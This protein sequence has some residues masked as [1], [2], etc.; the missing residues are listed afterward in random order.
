MRRSPGLTAAAIVTLALGIGANTSIFSLAS[1]LLLRPPPGVAAPGRVLMLRGEPHDLSAADVADYRAQA[2]A[3]S[4]LAARKAWAMD[5]RVGN[6]T[7]RINGALVGG[8]YFAVLGV[9]P[10]LGRGFGPDEDSGAPGAHPVAVIGH[11]LWRDRLG[12][13]PRA[14][15]RTIG[16]NGHPFTVIGV[17]PEGFRGPALFEEEALWVPLGMY[18]EVAPA[19][20]AGLGRGAGWLSAVGRLKPGVQAAGARS[21][22]EGI[23][24]RLALTWREDRDQRVVATG[25]DEQE[26]SGMIPYFGLLAAIVGAVLLIACANV[27]NLLLA[28]G[29]ARRR[30]FAVR[31]ALGAPRGRLVRQLLL[32]GLLLAGPGA[33]AGLL[34]TVW[35]TTPW[36]SGS[37]PGSM[38]SRAGSASRPTSGSWPSRSR[39][40]WCRASSSVWRRPSSFRVPTW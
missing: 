10:A 30:E 18:H 3:F 29:S 34:L 12:A 27:A 11:D 8:G 39:S 14:I 16:L 23:A 25:L 17:A 7:R 1:A 20:F 15:G 31:A 38:T 32:E 13:D 24:R 35:T 22:L 33:A 5:L 28:R 9:R 6:E 37:A 40:R 2:E 36:R 4:G 26:R 21:Q 19:L